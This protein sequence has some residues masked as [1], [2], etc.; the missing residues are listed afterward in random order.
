MIAGLRLAVPGTDV[1]SIGFGLG[2]HFFTTAQ[3]AEMHYILLGA[4]AHHV[5]VVAGSGD[6]GGFSDTWWF[7]TAVKEVSLPASDPL[8]LAAGGTRLTAN[9]LTGAHI[10]E[11]AWNSPPD[12]PAR[13]GS[14]ASGGG[15]SKVFRRPAYQDGVPGIGAT[16]GVPDVAAD[17]NGHTGMTIVIS[18]GNG[19][20]TIHN[21]GGTSASAPTWAGIIALADQYVGRNLGFVNPAIYR[22]ARSASYHQAFHDITIGN[23]TASFPPE[24]ITGYQAALGWDPVTGWGS[25]DAQ[26]L[27]PL[28]ARYASG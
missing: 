15:F 7:G 4:E 22:I 24:T 23:N 11:T 19:R 13:P 25:P 17:A 28:L 14:S 12:P 26:L 6:N 2:E 8:V 5:T 21:S 18:D 16:R 1:A 27:V 10:G 9:P 20:Y 3:A